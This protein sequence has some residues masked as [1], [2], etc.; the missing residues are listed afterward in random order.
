M[1]CTCMHGFKHYQN[2]V[3]AKQDPCIHKYG[4]S[5]RHEITHCLIFSCFVHKGYLRPYTTQCIMN[6][7]CKVFSSHQ[8]VYKPFA[9]QQA[10]AYWGTVLGNAQKWRAR[11]R[12]LAWCGAGL[13]RGLRR[14]YSHVFDKGPADWGT[15]HVA[16]IHKRGPAHVNV[17]V[18]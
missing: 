2:I 6:M 15:A 5:S 9:A 13:G 8:H 3:V 16:C 1:R 12:G 14:T 4:W 11:R 18:S 10:R 7:F 17:H